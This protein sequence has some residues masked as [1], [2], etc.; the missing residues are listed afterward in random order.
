MEK[1]NEIPPLPPFSSPEGEIVDFPMNPRQ[2]GRT[3]ARLFGTESRDCP[4]PVGTLD[5][6]EWFS[7]WIEYHQYHQ[8]TVRLPGASSA[9]VLPL[10]P[11][12]EG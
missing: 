12:L 9:T 10:R 5:W 3:G 1:K 7:G 6:F 8:Q 11:A 4:F 2:A